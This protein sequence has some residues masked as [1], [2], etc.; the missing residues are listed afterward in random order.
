MGSMPKWLWFIHVIDGWSM[1]MRICAISGP[2]L[3]S[4]IFLF[5]SSLECSA[6]RRWSLHTLYSRFEWVSHI[7]KE[8]LHIE[9]APEDMNPPKAWKW[10]PCFSHLRNHKNDFWE[11]KHLF[12]TKLWEMKFLVIG[13][14]LVTALWKLVKLDV[15]VGHWDFVDVIESRFAVC[16]GKS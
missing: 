9:K 11:S 4:I 3:W 6:T 13:S 16:E 12:S 1:R 10:R 8:L 7:A 14:K 15:E 5:K 2:F